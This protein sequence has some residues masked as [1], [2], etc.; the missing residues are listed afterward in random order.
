M[1]KKKAI[2][3]LSGGLDSV[4]CFY[5][6]IEEA[7]VKLCLTL[8]YGQ[9]ASKREIDASVR[10]CDDFNI[11]HRV[12]EI[13]WFTSFQN[14]ALVGSQSLPHLDE[15]ELDDF[16]QTKKTAAKVW[17]PNRNGVF[18]NVAASL[19]DH[20]DVDWIVIGFN[21]EEATTFPDN[22]KGFLDATNQSLQYSTK[23]Q[24]ELKA[25]MIDRD[26]TQIVKWMLEKAHDLSKIWSCYEGGGRMCGECE[27]CARLRRALKQA[28]ALDLLEE[29]F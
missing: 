1:K 10:L 27:S 2:V 17:V 18:I 23:N 7:D 22:S 20:E 19:A 11:P 3:L 24:V 26:K 8:D 6:A 25:P 12:I 16:E 29:L 14:N 13:P 9:K 21:K 4:A 5:W 15:N 28:E